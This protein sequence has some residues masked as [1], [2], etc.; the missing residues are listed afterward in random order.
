MMGVSRE[1]VKGDALSPVIHRRLPRHGHTLPPSPCACLVHGDARDHSEGC[2]LTSL[3]LKP[4]LSSSARAQC[5][6]PGPR[7]TLAQ[8]ATPHGALWL[9][10]CKL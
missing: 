9:L 5:C 8:T 4:L 2:T 6:L 10:S 1:G 7:A 3:P